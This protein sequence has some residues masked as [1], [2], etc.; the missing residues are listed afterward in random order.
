METKTREQE[1]DEMI[2]EIDSKLHPICRG[3]QR[4]LSLVHW[5]IRLSVEKDR[6]SRSR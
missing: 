5:R 1:V 2:A 4:L 3:D 6:L